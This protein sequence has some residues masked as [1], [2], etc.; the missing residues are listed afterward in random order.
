MSL[1]GDI[2]EIQET[3][4]EVCISGGGEGIEAGRESRVSKGS[5]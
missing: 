1:M 4:G 3:H 5:A 2:E